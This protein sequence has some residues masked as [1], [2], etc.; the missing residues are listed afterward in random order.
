MGTPKLSP[1]ALWEVIHALTEGEYRQLRARLRSAKERWLLDRLRRMK[2]YNESYLYQAYRR[3]FPHSSLAALRTHKHHLWEILSEVLPATM[4]PES[5]KEQRIWQ[6]LWFSIALWQRGLSDTALDLW[7]QAVSKAIELGWEEVVLWSIHVL[8]T[9]VRDYHSLAPGE[10]ISQ[11]GTALLEKINR[12]YT[13]LLGK[14]SA[15]EHHAVSRQKDGLTLPKIPP[16]D[17]WASYFEQYTL[18]L[19]ASEA[20]DMTRALDYLIDIL[21]LLIQKPASPSLYYIRHRFYMNYLAMGV[22]LLHVAE[23]DLFEQ[24]YAGWQSLEKSLPDF[25]QP[26]TLIA[27]ALTLRL[28]FLL[29]WGHWTE[30]KALCLSE[31]D[32]LLQYILHTDLSFMARPLAAC[33]V[34]FTLILAEDKDKSAETWY[35]QINPWMEESARDESAFLRWRLLRWY[36]A[37]RKKDYRAINYWYHRLRKTWRNN[38]IQAL[39]G[40]RAVLRAL[41]GLT[42]ELYGFQRR[43]LEVLLRRWKNRPSERHFWETAESIFFPLPLLIEALLKGVSL[44]CLRPQNALLPR[45]DEPLRQRASTVLYQVE[46]LAKQFGE[47]TDTADAPKR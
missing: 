28:A 8:E 34:Y 7:R 25:C 26:T 30:A 11:W 3:S 13:A 6:K 18:F 40:W 45:L 38:P 23:P 42:P 4:L 39:F 31:H 33:T 35:E 19:R 21:D 12:R 29:R 20:A 43:R 17:L 44:E 10:S 15:M 14:L 2:I 22:P 32:R 1:E 9:Y 47:A 24:W 41:R 36:A 27:T 5:I 16:D 46:N 37:F